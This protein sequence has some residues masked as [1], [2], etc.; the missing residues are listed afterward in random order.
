M[1]KTRDTIYAFVKNKFVSP[2]CFYTLLKLNELFDVWFFQTQVLLFID[3]FEH[4]TN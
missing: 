3:N 2:E 4:K 1:L